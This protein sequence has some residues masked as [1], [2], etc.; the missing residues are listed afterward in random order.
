VLRVVGG[1]VKVR[2]LLAVGKLH[3]EAEELIGKRL[4]SQGN[5]VQQVRE[6]LLLSG[7]TLR[8]RR[9]RVKP[10]PAR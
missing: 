5:A 4:T 2:R 9:Q 3:T 1:R 8:K 7:E 6:L 10:N